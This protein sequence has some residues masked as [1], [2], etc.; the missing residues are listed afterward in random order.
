[1][2]RAILAAQRVG[3]EVTRSELEERFIVFLERHGLPRPEV[4]VGLAVHGTWLEVD[5]LWRSS[6]LIVELDGRAAH[7]PAAAFERDRARDRA[8]AAA[9]FQAIRITWRH[10]HDEPEAVA[11][12]LRRLLGRLAP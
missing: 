9:G 3:A 4:N 1:V 10:L 8:L 2:I 12:D 6:R 7:E 5:C 11:A